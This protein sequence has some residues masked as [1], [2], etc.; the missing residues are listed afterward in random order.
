MGWEYKITRCNLW[1]NVYRKQEEDW[2]IR[3]EWLQRD[4]Y[5]LNKDFARTFY[6]L[7]DAISAL[8]KARIIWKKE[9]STTSEE[10]SGSEGGKE[11]TSWS[12]FWS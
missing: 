2:L 7:D 3:L 11:K 10:K 5:T 12:E 8:I 4:T 6:H 1:Y 9:T